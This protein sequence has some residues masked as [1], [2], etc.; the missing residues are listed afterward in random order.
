MTDALSELPMWVVTRFPS[1][2]PQH[3]V[4]RLN[5]WD[6]ASKAY[7]PTGEM[8][9]RKTREEIDLVMFA[10]G[11]TFLPRHPQDEPVILGTWL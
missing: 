8:I 3:Y 6:E 10:K 7:Y 2:Y 9:L 5:R 11:L 1:D 4:A